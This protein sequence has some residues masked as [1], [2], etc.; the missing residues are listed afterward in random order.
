M[1]SELASKTNL[2][3]LGRGLVQGSVSSYARE[4]AADLRSPVRVAGVEFLVLH[5]PRGDDVESRYR[6]YPF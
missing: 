4:K 6:N 1:I 2:L 5:H 3:H